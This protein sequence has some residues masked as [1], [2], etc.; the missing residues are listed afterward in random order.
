MIPKGQI[1]V[2]SPFDKPH[3][4]SSTMPLLSL[5]FCSVAA[6]GITSGLHWN[7][8]ACDLGQMASTQESYIERPTIVCTE[9]ILTYFFLQFPSSTQSAFEIFSSVPNNQKAPTFPV[10]SLSQRFS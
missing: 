9:Q 7:P 5:F 2:L 8:R 10:S 4:L 1:T 3:G 6:W